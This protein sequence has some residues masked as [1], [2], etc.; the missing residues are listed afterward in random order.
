MRM[1]LTLGRS[2]IAIMTV[3]APRSTRD[4]VRKGSRAQ[5]DEHALTILAG[6]RMT[7]MPW[8]VP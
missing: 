7:H 2:L 6:S 8:R 1:A 3:V 5:R 4:S